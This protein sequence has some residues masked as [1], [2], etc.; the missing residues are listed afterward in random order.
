MRHFLLF[1]LCFVFTQPVLADSQTHKYIKVVETNVNTDC[2]GAA[3]QTN[4]DS[5]EVG[6]GGILGR[7]LMKANGWPSNG[8]DQLC[9]IGTADDGT[10]YK[11]SDNLYAAISPHLTTAELAAVV[12]S[13]PAGYSSSS[14]VLAFLPRWNKTNILS[15]GDSIEFGLGTTSGDYTDIYLYQGMQLLDGYEDDYYYIST[16]LGSSSFGNDTGSYTTYPLPWTTSYLQRHCTLPLDN[17]DVIFY[18]GL[19]TNDYAYGAGGT[20]DATIYSRATTRF[21]R[22]KADHP[23][24]V[25]VAGTIIERSGNST[26]GDVYDENIRTNMDT[27]NVDIVLDLSTIGGNIDSGDFTDGVHLTTAGHAKFDLASAETILIG[28]AIL[29]GESFDNPIVATKLPAIT[30]TEQVGETLTCDIGSPVLTYSYVWENEGT[31][32]SGATSATYTL[33]ASD[34]GDTLTCLVEPISSYGSLTAPK[35]SPASGTIAAA[36]AVPSN[37][38][39]PAISGT[40]AVGETLTCST[41]TWTGSPSSYAY[42]WENENVDIGGETSNTYVLQASDEGDTLTCGVIATNATGSSAEAESAATGTI[43]AAPTV[44][45]GVDDLAT[46]T[47]ASTSIPLTWTAPSNGGAA[48]T[49]YIVEYSSTSGVAGFATFSDGTSA[50]TG[51]TVTGLTASTQYWFKVGAVNSVGTSA[52]SNVVTATTAAASSFEPDDLSNLVLWLDATDASTITESGGAV[53]AWSD[54]STAG[55]DCSQGTGANQPTISSGVITFD[56]SNDSLTCGNP[57]WFDSSNTTE[58]STI[59]VT[60]S[61]ATT[62]AGYI[63]SNADVNNGGG[64]YAHSTDDKVHLADKTSVSGTDSVVRTGSG[65]EHV[66]FEYAADSVQGVI[67][68]V[69]TGT[70]TYDYLFAPSNDNFIIGNRPAGSSAGTY[71]DGDIMGIVIYERSDLTDSEKNDVGNHLVAQHGG[72][73]TGL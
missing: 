15:H 11:C 56:G 65:V 4:G 19:G 33:Q 34:E 16:A 71:L 13:A 2:G 3:T 5:R 31:P 72:T 7:K 73:W 10:Y 68:G 61:I 47:V 24:V 67:N 55:N 57:A 21:S 48:I 43:G 8:V 49:D 20:P 50:S 54:K 38:V 17:T 22:I 37:T 14:G 36:P 9:E 59:F 23:N 60:F 42:T 44:P 18:V 40:E 69:D 63:L 30:G 35:E 66:M 28:R 25:L 32:I 29:A 46:G 70:N 39:L 51:A 53:S 27:N 58:N 1:L 26:F 6:N 41:G 62:E 52:D 12:S 45:D 64:I